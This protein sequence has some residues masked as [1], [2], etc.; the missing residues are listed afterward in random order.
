VSK[1]QLSNYRIILI[2]IGLI[3]VLLFASPTI[4]LLVKLPP[5]QEYSEIY[6]LGPNHDLS[7]LPFYIEPNVSYLLYLG[8]TNNLKSAGY[9]TCLMKFGNDSTLLPNQALG[10][11]SSLPSLYEYNVFLDSGATWE[12]PFTFEIDTLN[13]ANNTAEVSGVNINGVDYPISLTSAWDSNRT[14]YFYNFIVELW[15]FNGTQGA[16]QYNDRFVSLILNMNQ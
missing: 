8:I 12:T 1:I 16:I 11:P 5:G 3:G 6:L 7:N 15:L 2:T 10:T 14:G 4:A 9:Y 13:F